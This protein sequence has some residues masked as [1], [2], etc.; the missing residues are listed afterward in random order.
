MP[1]DFLDTSALAKHYHVE[2]GTAEID[3]LWDDSVHGLFISR[4]SVVEFTSVFA[5][6]VRE[7]SIAASDFAALQTVFGRLDQVETTDRRPASRRAF[8]RSGTAPARTRLGST[9]SHTRR[10]AIGHRA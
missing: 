7:C 6:K 2:V 1:A 8:S 9:S 4:L 5:R 10:I 3:S